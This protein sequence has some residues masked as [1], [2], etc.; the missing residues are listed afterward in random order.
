MKAKAKERFQEGKKEKMSEEWLICPGCGEMKVIRLQDLKQREDKPFF[1]DLCGEEI[2]FASLTQEKFSKEE[3]KDP[4]RSESTH[5][6]EQTIP[7]KNKE[8]TKHYSQERINPANQRVQTDKKSKQTQVYQPLSPAHQAQISSHITIY[9]GAYRLMQ[10]P[11]VRSWFYEDQTELEFWQ[12][13]YL[14]CKL[15]ALIK[16]HKF[17]NQETMGGDPIRS[18]FIRHFT[19]LQRSFQDRKLFRAQ[20]RTALNNVLANVF[21]L[22]RAIPS[23]KLSPQFRQHFLEAAIKEFGLTQYEIKPY[24]FYHRILLFFAEEFYKTLYYPECPFRVKTNNGKFHQKGLTQFSEGLLRLAKEKG[25]YPTFIKGLSFWERYC[26]QKRYKAW[27]KRI[28]EDAIYRTSVKKIFW[29]IIICVLYLMDGSLRLTSENY[30]LRSIA[31]KLVFLNFFKHDFRFPEEFRTGVKLL[32]GR[33]TLGKALHDKR[34]SKG[35]ALLVSHDEEQVHIFA[36]NLLVLFRQRLFPINLLAQLSPLPKEQFQHYLTELY[37]T[38][39]TDRIYQRSFVLFCRNTVTS[40]LIFLEKEFDDSS[41]AEPQFT[42]FELMLFRDYSNL[43]DKSRF[44]AFFQKREQPLGLKHYPE[45][46]HM[47]KLGIPIHDKQECKVKIQEHFFPACIDTGSSVCLMSKEIAN[48]LFPHKKRHNTQLS[49]I[50]RI[51]AQRKL[52]KDI[53]YSLYGFSYRADFIIE[54]HIEQ[55]FHTPI[56]LSRDALNNFLQDKYG[57]EFGDLFQKKERSMKMREYHS[58]Q[59][60]SRAI[61]P[62]IRAILQH[63]RESPLFLDDFALYAIHSY[64][65]AYS[66]LPPSLKQFLSEFKYVIFDKIIADI[67]HDK[68]DLAKQL[69]QYGKE[70]KDSTL[71][72]K[73]NC[74]TREL[75][76]QS[77]SSPY[78]IYSFPSSTPQHIYLKA[79]KLVVLTG[80]RFES[81]QNRLDIYEQLHQKHLQGKNIRAINIENLLI[82]QALKTEG[83]MKLRT[84]IEDQVRKTA[85][86]AENFLLRE[87]ESFST[88]HDRIRCRSLREDNKESWNTIDTNSSMDIKYCLGLRTDKKEELIKIVE[89][90]Y[91]DISFWTSSQRQEKDVREWNDEQIDKIFCKINE[92]EIFP[93]QLEKYAQSTQ[94]Q[95]RLLIKLVPIILD[96]RH[97]HLYLQEIKE[98]FRTSTKFIYSIAKYLRD[99]YKEHL[100]LPQGKTIPPDQVQEIVFLTKRFYDNNSFWTTSQISEGKSSFNRDQTK[101]ILNEVKERKIITKPARLLSRKD[102]SYILG[103]IKSVP[104]ILN[105]RDNALYLKEISEI[106]SLGIEKISEIGHLFLNPNE[107]EQRFLGRDP[108]LR[109]TPPTGYHW[110]KETKTKFKETVKHFITEEVMRQIIKFIIQNFYKDDDFWISSQRKEFTKDQKRKIADS[111]FSKFDIYPNDKNISTI[112]NMICAIPLILDNSINRLNSVEISKKCGISRSTIAKYKKIILPDSHFRRFRGRKTEEALSIIFRKTV[113]Y[114]V[115]HKIASTPKIKISLDYVLDS[116]NSSQ[117]FKKVQNVH[118]SKKLIKEIQTALAVSLDIF[119]PYFGDFKKIPISL[120]AEKN[121]VGDH[122]VTDLSQEVSEKFPN[123][124]SHNVRFESEFAPTLG[125]YAHYCLKKILTVYFREL[126]IKYFSEIVPFANDSRIIDGFIFLTEKVLDLLDNKVL[127]IL[128]I[129]NINSLKGILIDF[130]SNISELNILKKCLKYQ[131]KDLLLFIVGINYWIDKNDF[132]KVPND[133]KI[134]YSNNIRMVN[135][136]LFSDLFEIDKKPKTLKIIQ[137]IHYFLAREKLHSLKE[138]DKNLLNIKFGNPSFIKEVEKLDIKF[139]RSERELQIQDRFFDEKGLTQKTLFDPFH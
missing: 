79:E 51:P 123:L 42:D 100:T 82:N 86:H 75:Q 56:V 62:E 6:A 29:K 13:W 90:F 8:I 112:S 135:L 109:K 15:H 96:N 57:I 127:Q 97:N 14:R 18:A 98:K 108:F 23:K 46:F 27:Q 45:I 71:C 21:C 99:D 7:R 12:R 136:S 10:Q 74:E 105:R 138:L 37:L 65:T 89:K 61:T 67:A 68:S 88:N 5:H 9:L 115:L 128:G 111:I 106:T 35:K 22:M 3:D 64:Y 131:H 104:L 134:I 40:I 132:I 69:L 55:L 26:F 43:E 66:Q 103:V 78:K 87:K 77:Q 60:G 39:K 32:I 47:S 41:K 120:V 119:R 110:S 28:Q 59:I 49:G 81:A 116:I 53:P 48:K 125:N 24:N 126:S 19:E 34:E 83:S 20:G 17:R 4:S 70:N 80:T 101:T 30:F 118:L 76:I 72:S 85:P 124:Y 50:Q 38:L 54:K 58:Q 102:K 52:L 122:Y 94:D 1:C 95:I 121:G 63:H 33:I 107:Y 92:L 25:A 129:K 31:H 117:F 84:I 2:Q 44:F 139:L 91:N 11:K 36:E 114:F 137:S 113:S 133:P 73:C 130:T 93:K 16:H